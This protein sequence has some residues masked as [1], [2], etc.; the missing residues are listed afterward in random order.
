M[1][2]FCY[3]WQ[4]FSRVF[5]QAEL[6]D[7]MMKRIGVRRAVAVRVDQGMAWYDART[8]CIDCLA[9]RQ[10]RGWLENTDET[11]IPHDFCPNAQFFQR[12]IPAGVTPVLRGHEPR[13]LSSRSGPRV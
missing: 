10:C 6:M 9:D 13:Q 7:R 12:C 8:K 11:A 2:D 4:I 1:G 3:G 5:R